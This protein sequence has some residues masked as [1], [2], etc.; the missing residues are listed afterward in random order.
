MS[1]QEVNHFVKNASFYAASQLYK[2]P[3]IC[4]EYETLG[5]LMQLKTS[6]NTSVTYFFVK[7]IF[8]FSPLSFLIHLCIFVIVPKNHIVLLHNL[9][10]LLQKPLH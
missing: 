5:Q 9:E 4:Y 8:N 3:P 7:P 6:E 10:D 1:Y 2:L